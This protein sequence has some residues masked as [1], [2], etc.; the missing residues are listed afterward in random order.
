MELTNY[1][2]EDEVMVEP[3]RKKLNDFI[4]SIS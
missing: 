2:P 4:W 3:V 1:E